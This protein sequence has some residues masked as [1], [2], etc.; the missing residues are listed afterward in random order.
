MGKVKTPFDDAIESLE[1]EL[2]D[3]T[4]KRAEYICPFKVGDVLVNKYG[5]V[6]K[7]LRIYPGYAGYR[8]NGEYRRKN[9]TYGRVGELSG[10]A[11]WKKADVQ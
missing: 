3:I 5:K 6:A 11:D 9:G 8:M 10:W 1:K 2:A 7:V 4:Q